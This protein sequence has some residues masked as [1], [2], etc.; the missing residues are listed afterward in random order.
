MGMPLKS[1]YSFS[2]LAKM[3]R[4]KERGVVVRSCSTDQKRSS[5]L[6]VI[7]NK[8][9]EGRQIDKGKKTKVKTDIH[10]QT[11]HSSDTGM[12]ATL[13]GIKNV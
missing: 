4:L 11:V 1:G 9:Q 3:R 10:L 12:K 2:S 13:I 6:Q 7:W 5:T 8:V